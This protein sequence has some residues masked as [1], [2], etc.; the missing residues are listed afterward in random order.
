MADDQNIGEDGEQVEDEDVVAGAP[1]DP[2]P[3][4]APDKRTDGQKAIDEKDASRSAELKKMAS[5]EAKKASAVEMSERHGLKNTSDNPTNKLGA[6]LSSAGRSGVGIGLRDSSDNP[7]TNLGGGM[8]SLSEMH[9]KAFGGGGEEAKPDEKAQWERDFAGENLPPDG[10]VTEEEWVA[11]K[12]EV[13]ALLGEVNARLAS[14]EASGGALDA[15]STDFSSTKDAMLAGEADLLSG[16]KDENDYS[17]ADFSDDIYSQHVHD[18][19]EVDD[20]IP[21]PQATCRVKMTTSNSVVEDS[22]GPT[23]LAGDF[24]SSPVIETNDSVLEGGSDG[25]TVKKGHSGIYMLDMNIVGAVT[26]QSVGGAGYIAVDCTIDGAA[27]EEPKWYLSK[28]FGSGHGVTGSTWTEAGSLDTD[29]ELGVDETVEMKN[30]ASAAIFVDASAGNVLV[31]A[32]YTLVG[33]DGSA[34]FLVN[35]FTLTLLELRDSAT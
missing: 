18:T 30:S 8:P 19:E 25:V 31:S 35:A 32:D 2:A 4:A 6:N 27:G 10:Q 26:I 15:S 22:A 29:A 28:S 24:D 23:A 21:V 12:D 20:P 7:R 34:W 14:L 1:L 5:R 17:D 3:D 13:N 16:V 33:H 11:A 9:E